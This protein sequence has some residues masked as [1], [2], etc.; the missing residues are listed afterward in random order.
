MILPHL[1]GQEIDVYYSIKKYWS[2]MRELI[3][4]VLQWR[5]MDRMLAEEMAVLPGMEETAAFLWLE[6]FYRT[7]GYDLIVI[8]SAPTGETLK[9]LTLPQVSQWWLTKVLPVQKLAKNSM[10]KVVRKVTGI[11]LD[12][13]LQEL[14]TFYDKLMQVNE[15]MSKPNICTIRLVMNPERMVI[16]EAL[17][18]YTYLQLYGY[19]VDG[20]V[21]NRILPQESAEAVFS[22][23]VAA[24]QRYL[25]EI[26]DSFAPLPIFHVPHL[27]QEVFGPDRLR[28]I[29]TELYQD[30]DPRK[31][32]YAQK[33]YH[34]IQQQDGYLLSIQLPFLKQ[35]EVSVNQFGDEL[36]IQAKNRRR[37]LFL[38]QF[39]AYY[40][41]THTQM[42]DGRLLIRFEKADKN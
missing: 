12:K 4:S 2:R 24:Q 8:D 38:P 30:Q 15:L 27:G 6:L 42:M 10:G 18:A 22:D 35:Q 14:E 21:V 16:Q 33:P 9:H 41:V 3:L 29:V 5:G 37:N 17:R 34:F 26:S 11:P 32:F 20:V 19:A 36:V 7:G 25:E 39:M 23:Y 40:R 13:G 1:Y 31:V 28:Q